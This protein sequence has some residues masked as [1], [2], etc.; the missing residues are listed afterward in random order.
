MFQI[1][2]WTIPFRI[3]GDERVNPVTPQVTFELYY[4]IRWK[5]PLLEHIG[6][7]DLDK[8]SLVAK[9]K[10]HQLMEMS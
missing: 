2:A 6:V 7:T 5:S 1:K 4:I 10:L 9:L 3:L 8:V